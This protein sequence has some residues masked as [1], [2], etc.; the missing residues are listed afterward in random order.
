MV[1]ISQFYIFSISSFSMM[2]INR[3]QAQGPTP[4][5]N[6][7]PPSAGPNWI[8]LMVSVAIITVLIVIIGVWINRNVNSN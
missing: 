5:S 6:S 3:I 8:Q 7:I 1:L 2:S 4:A